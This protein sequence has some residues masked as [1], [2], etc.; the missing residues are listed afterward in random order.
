MDKDITKTTFLQYL[1]PINFK[2]FEELIT[3]LGVDKYVKKLSTSKMIILLIYSQLFNVDSLSHLSTE[4][5]CDDKLS[6]LINL[7]SISTSQLSRK[8]R[9]LTPDLI[10][11]IFNQLV[12]KAIAKNGVNA[13]RKKLNHVN[14]IDASTISM[15]IS[16]YPWADFRTTKAGVKLNLRIKF[17]D[18]SDKIMP[19]K[20]V[21][22]PA[23]Q[24]DR[25]KMDDLVITSE[26]ALNIFDR[27]YVDYE[28][29]D[30]YTDNNV[31][32]LSRLKGN[33]KVE[34][35]NTGIKYVD[36]KEIKDST[37]KLGNKGINQMKNNLRLL[38]I[39][40]DRD[41]D[42]IIKIITNDFERSAK[43]I[44]DLYRNRW[45]IE[46]FFK[47]I[48]Q[49]LQVK[50]FYGFS[51]TAVENQIMSALITHLLLVF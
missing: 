5:T 51:Q 46:L 18:Q 15:A 43:E 22:S 27:G 8:L 21:I 39:P 45:K 12:I 24:A 47:W 31:L 14:V 32:F 17:C 7:D 10:E 37:V 33:A 11:N 44:S 6:E 41:P 42:K 23:K 48:K 1:G 38:E 26:N 19:D 2:K 9:D 3:N 28:K 20:V 36:G 25:T 34:Y 29:F 35:I 30:D 50:K 16:Q 40:D 4:L 13:V 49:H